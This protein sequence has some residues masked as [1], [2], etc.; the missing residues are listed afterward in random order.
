MD[1]F[2]QRRSGGE[3]WERVKKIKIEKIKKEQKG[4]T[5]RKIQDNKILGRLRLC[6]RR[7][8]G[9]DSRFQQDLS[10]PDDQFQCALVGARVRSLLVIYT[11]FV[12]M[13]VV[14]RRIPR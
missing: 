1:C 8:R 13:V 2:N 14:R 4:E 11:S 7:C 5:R 9:G 3:K 6:S 12:S 10:M